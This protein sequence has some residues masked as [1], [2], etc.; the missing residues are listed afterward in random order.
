MKIDKPGDRKAYYEAGRTWADDV[1]GAL[2]ASRRTAWIVAGAAAAIALL[3][4]VAIALMAPL[5]TVEPYVLTLDRQTGYM[6]MAPGLK[7][8]ALSQDEAVHQ[9]FLA[10]YVI[11]REGF[12]IAGLQMNYR[13]VAAWTEGGARAA[14]VAAMSGSNP[15]S[16]VK[17]Y[18]AGTVVS[19]TVKSVA[20]IGRSTAQVRFDTQQTSADGVSMPPRAYQATIGFR[21]TGAPMRM[22]DRLL[23]PLGFKVTSYRRDAEAAR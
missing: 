2:R 5:K 15:Q 22:D 16:P 21:Y 11:A 19:V 12:D 14:Y 18:D 8:G 9:A 6:S 3:E 20:M 23:N 10:Q 17:L 1:H 7:T 13:N 4:A